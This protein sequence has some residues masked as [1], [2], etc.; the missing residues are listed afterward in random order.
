MNTTNQFD[1]PP[2]WLKT[3]LTLMGTAMA[4][5]LVSFVFL[6]AGL[7]NGLRTS[8]T[9]VEATHHIVG[10]NM[11]FSLEE[12]AVKQGEPVTVRLVNDDMF[13]HSF[14]IDSLGI[15]V[16]MPPNEESVVT[17]TP[18]EP[19]TYRIYCAVRGHEAAG[20]V[21]TLVVTP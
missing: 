10:E 21:S 3:S 1:H 17:F 6:R 14:D 8:P 4:I 15:H 13:A 11:R 16:D 5:L 19:G 20:M 2:T 12:L 18:T 7:L 9:A